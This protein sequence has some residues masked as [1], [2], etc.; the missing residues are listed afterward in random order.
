MTPQG[1]KGMEPDEAQMKKVAGH[2]NEDDY[3]DIIGGRV[4]RGPHTGKT[5]VVDPYDGRHSVKSGRKSWQVFLYAESRLDSNTI[6]QGIG[7]VATLLGD[8]LRVF[9]KDRATMIDNRDYYKQSLQLPIRELSNELQKDNVFKAFWHKAL[10]DGEVEYLGILPPSF[11]PSIARSADKH[12]HIF[13]SDEVIDIICANTGANTSKQYTKHQ[14]PAQK[15][16]FPTKL[17]GKNKLLNLGEIE[18]RVDPKN[19][20]LAK[21]WI[22]PDRTFTLLRDHLSPTNH[23][24]SQIT[25]YGKAK[26]LKLASPSD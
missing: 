7:N 11:D 1:Y 17:K 20:R 5:D 2:T 3:A 10:F 6:L 16:I 15:V 23:P 8:C 14:T 26:R 25:A 12:F 24:H 4:T 19:Y 13:D 18:I 21:M 22:N 9:P